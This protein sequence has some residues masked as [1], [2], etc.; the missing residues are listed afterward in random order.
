MVPSLCCVVEEGSFCLSDYIF[1]GHAFVKGSADEFVEFVDIGCH[2]LVVVIEQ[3]LLRYV[4]SQSLHVV[5]QG[6]EEEFSGGVVCCHDC[7]I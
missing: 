7:R 6:G 4:G 1:D 5:R 3:C 2:V